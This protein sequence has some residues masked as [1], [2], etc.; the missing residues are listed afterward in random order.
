MLRV[1]A[2]TYYGLASSMLKLLAKSSR[3]WRQSTANGE[4]A[5]A[6]AYKIVSIP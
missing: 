1:V 3:Q 2:G 4:E 5:L 6:V